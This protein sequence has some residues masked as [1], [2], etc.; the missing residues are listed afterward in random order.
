MRARHDGPGNCSGSGSASGP[1]RPCSPTVS[2]DPEV[3]GRSRPIHTAL[4][5][6]KDPGTY[7]GWGEGLR[8]PQL[9]KP[10]TCS[11][12]INLNIDVRDCGRRRPTG[13][14]VAAVPESMSAPAAPPNPRVNREWR[15]PR[16]DWS[17]VILMSQGGMVTG[18]PSAHA[19]SPRFWGWRMRVESPGF[20]NEVHHLLRVLPRDDALRTSPLK[21]GVTWPDTTPPAPRAAN[22][23]QVWIARHP[24]KSQSDSDPTSLHPT[25]HPTRPAGPRNRLFTTTGHQ[26]VT[27]CP[28]VAT[29]RTCPSYPDS[30]HSPR[31][32]RNPSLPMPTARAV[33]PAHPEACR[34]ACPEL[35]E[36]PALSL[37]KCLP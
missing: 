20:T 7:K 35:A 25:A 26:P 27:H 33:P 28:P 30:V 13:H 17:W 16:G 5:D 15:G 14:G 10:T 34:S 12:A 8:S 19:W 6:S 31:L 37:P 36:V 2:W 24:P 21:T 9:K 4:G 11:T 29:R 1:G 18:G 23:Q 22:S 32:P 3:I